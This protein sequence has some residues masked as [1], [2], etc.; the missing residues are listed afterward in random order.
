[1][2]KFK[3]GTRDSQ[4]ALWQAKWVKDKLQELYPEVDFILIPMKTKGDKILDVPLAK[5]GD[6]GLFTKELEVGLLSGE[7]DCAVHSLKDLPTI[8]PAGLDIAVFCEREEPRDVF[9]S[10]EGIQLADLPA[11]SI[12]GTSSLRRKA[13][14]QNYRS[15]L[16]F[17]DLR[18]NLQTRWRKLQES[19]MAGIVLAAA[20]VKRL[21][22]EE[23]ITEYIPQ[24][25]ML[26]AVGQGAIA[27]EVVS[28]REDV[29]ELLSALNHRETERA[30]RAERALLLRLEGGCQIPIGALAVTDAQQINLRGMVASL[31]GQRVLK[32]S[33]TGDDPEKLGKEAAEALIAQGALDILSEIRTNLES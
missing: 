32:V 16:G 21:G 14:L 5:I 6:K 33:L 18:G 13:Q 3:I 25:I 15:D 26:S 7:I 29:R 9:L 8:L 22:W 11:G 30:V 10:R 17:A 28:D 23:R 31:D 1:M 20:G 24:E 2:Q 12:I 4:L 19:T 27:V